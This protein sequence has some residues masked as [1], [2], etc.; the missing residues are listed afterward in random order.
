MRRL[1][2]TSPTL[3]VLLIIPSPSIPISLRLL[4]QPVNPNGSAD[5]LW[6]NP[7]AMITLEIRLSVGLES[8][9]RPATLLSSDGLDRE[10]GSTN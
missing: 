4:W 3:S 10:T 8:G 2:K 1:T 9:D 7:Q 6:I 5:L